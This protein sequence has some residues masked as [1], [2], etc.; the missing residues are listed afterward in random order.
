MTIRERLS[1]DINRIQ[2]PI[3]LNRILEFIQLISPKNSSDK[4]NVNQLMKYAGSLPDEDANEMKKI[5]NEEFN[6]IE[7]EW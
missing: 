4:G 7:G 5:I 6:K 2:N 1:K 3:L